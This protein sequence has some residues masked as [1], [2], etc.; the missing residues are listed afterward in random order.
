VMTVDLA[1]KRL[2]LSI[3]AVQEGTAPGA[4]GARPS[5]GAGAGKAPP[6]SQGRPAGGGGNKPPAPEKRASA[7]PF[8]NPFRNLKR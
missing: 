8:N 1:R 4:S 7:E 5:G 6:P 3:R 2:G